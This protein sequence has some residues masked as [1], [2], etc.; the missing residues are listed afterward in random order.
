VASLASAVGS[1]NARALLHTVAAK[2]RKKLTYLARTVRRYDIFALDWETN[3]DLLHIAAVDSVSMARAL[4]GAPWG[5][6]W[7]SPALGLYHA[8]KH[9][10]SHLWLR[11]GTPLPVLI[12][13]PEVPIPRLVLQLL[14]L[15]RALSREAGV[16]Q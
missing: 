6:H 4:A 11:T 12:Q 3:W 13:E 2:W 5:P 8:A 14:G 7:R 10:Y 9:R 15:G 16:R 1:W